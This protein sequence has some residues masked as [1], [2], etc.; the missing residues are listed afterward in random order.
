MVTVPVSVGELID[1]LS[2]LHVKQ[3]KIVNENKLSFINK[4]F[5]LI[6]NMSSMYLDDEKILDLY[7][8][9]IEVNLSLWDVE[10]ELRT[11]E[12]TK[13]FDSHFI[14]LARKVYYINDDRFVLKNQINELTD[15]EVRE[16]KDY[17]EYK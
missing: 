16:Q 3:L 8:Q 13:N 7:R 14:E 17:I 1:K 6:Y 11:I 12:T 4:E 5:E 9:L 2:I 15:S 10:D